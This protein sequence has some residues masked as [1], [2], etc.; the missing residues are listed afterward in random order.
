MTLVEVLVGIIVAG[1]MVTLISPVVVLATATRLQT[2]RAEQATN[3]AQS[4]VDRARSLITR[5]VK[6][7]DEATYF[8]PATTGT[9]SAVAAP[10][11]LVSESTNPT[12]ASK[13]REVDING[14]GQSDFFIQTFRDAGIRF[15]YGSV[16]NQLANF[17]MGVRV[18]AIGAKDNLNS[19][20]T[21]PASLGLATSMIETQTQPLVVLY[22]DIGRSDVDASLTKLRCYID[23]SECASSP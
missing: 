15:N 18:Y 5:G 13:A 16:N 12:G 9:L 4:E 2:T 20:G 11:E 23:S 21:Q 8:P 22:T 14:D 17:R 19:L 6:Q 7:S 3:L 1:I 10:T